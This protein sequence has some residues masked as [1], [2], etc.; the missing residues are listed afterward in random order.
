MS[1]ETSTEWLA[2]LKILLAVLLN[3]EGTSLY[4]TYCDFLIITYS[5]PY[6]YPTLC[7]RAPSC[8]NFR[9]GISFRFKLEFLAEA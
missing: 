8:L 4:I 6:L 1:I 3:D 9:F 7:P 2:F 5:E